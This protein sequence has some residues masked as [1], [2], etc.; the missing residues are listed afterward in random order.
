MPPMNW[1][2][3]TSEEEYSQIKQ[4]SNSRPQVI[5]KHSTRCSI[6]SM[7][8]H[9][10]EQAFA[11]GEMDF[12]HLDI[13]RHRNLSNQIATDLDVWHESPQIIVIK[14]EV[15]VYDE[16]HSGIRMEYITEH[17]ELS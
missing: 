2:D 17:A 6:S 15:S 8:K 12:Y 14:N 13:L 11:P 4:R 10:L 9:R 16:S 1:I 5:F 7:A 3:L